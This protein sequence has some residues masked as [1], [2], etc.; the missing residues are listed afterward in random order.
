MRHILAP[1]ALIFAASAA[2]A[3]EVQEAQDNLKTAL[4]AGGCFWCME[5]AFDAVEGVAETT[6]GFAGGETADPEYR[7][8]AAGQ[9]GH[10]ETVRVRY[11]PD[12]VS[13]K[14][15]L[16]VYWTNVDPFDGTGQF[17]DRGS[18][19]RPAIFP[20]NERQRTLAKRS[21]QVLAERFDQAIAVRIHPPGPFWPAGEEH[22]DYHKENPLAYR[23]YKWRCGRS[24]RLEEIWGHDPNGPFEAI[25]ASAGGA[26][27]GANR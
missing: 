17:C 7:D 5:E 20:L 16:N 10:M 2:M 18:P 21:K 6:S 9:T 23:Y 19:Y 24:S 14:Q 8:V 4:F 27:S 11:A 1:L 22:Q 25:A 3:Q 15:L 26:Q 13:Y 12:T